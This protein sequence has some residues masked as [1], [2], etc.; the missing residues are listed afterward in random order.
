[1]GFTCLFQTGIHAVMTCRAGQKI[2]MRQDGVRYQRRGR[3][4]Y[5]IYMYLSSIRV[6]SLKNSK[7]KCWTRRT[8]T[9]GKTTTNTWI[10]RIKPF[11]FTSLTLK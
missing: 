4:R 10:E 8:Y 3:G 1:M 2:S 7:P 5:T 11:G 9:R 6:E